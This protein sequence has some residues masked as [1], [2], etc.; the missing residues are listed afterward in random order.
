M[1]IRKSA[2][3]KVMLSHNYNHFEASIALENED[4][5]TVEDID[6][7]RKDCNRLCDKAIK[8]YNIAKVME[9]KRASLSNEKRNLEREVTEIKQKDK[10]TWTVIEKAKVKAL[11][12]HNWELLWDYDD[13]SQGME[14]A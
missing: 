4:G 5:V 9:S 13:E 10:D 14:D 8:Q 7:A 3:V 2:T 1:T 11:E 12:D 6:N